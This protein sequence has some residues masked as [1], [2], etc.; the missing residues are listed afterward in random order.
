MAVL[1]PEKKPAKK[2]PVGSVSSHEIQQ[3]ANNHVEGDPDGR[4]IGL[5]KGTKA[6]TNLQALDFV[7]FLACYS[8]VFFLNWS[9]CYF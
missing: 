5:S 2:K 4:E 7:Q 3:K 8:S 9:C 1:K 6:I